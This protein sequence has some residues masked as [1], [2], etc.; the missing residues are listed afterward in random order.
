VGRGALIRRA[1]GGLRRHR[2]FGLL[3]VLAAGLRAIVLLAY[4][5]ALIF[6]DSVRYLQYAQHFAD[7]RWTVDG[8]R[9]AAERVFG[10]AHPGHAVA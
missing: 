1:R 4:H 5:P 2:G 3:L 7:G 10:A 8:G 9:A 6:P